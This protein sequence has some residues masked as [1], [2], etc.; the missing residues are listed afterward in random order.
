MTVPVWSFVDSAA[1]VP[2]V[3]V[4]PAL[5]VTQLQTVHLVVH[6]AIPAQHVSVS[7]PQVDNFPDDTTGAA[8]GTDAVYDFT[9]ARA[10]TFIYQAGG[11]VDGAR[12]AAMGLIGALVVVPENG[13]G[14]AYGSAGSAF[15]DQGVI[16]I[17][18]VDPG[19]NNAPTTFDMRN[20]APHFRLYNGAA[21]PATTAIPVTAGG[22]TLLRLVNG[23]IIQ[24]AVGVQGAGVTVFAQSAHPLRIPYGV[25]AENIPAGD[26][27]DMLVK[28]PAAEGL[29]YAVYDP[30]MRLDNDGAASSTAAGNIVAFGGGLT[31]LQSSGTGTPTNTAPVVSA[32]TIT[33]TVMGTAPTPVTFN[34]TI[35]DDIAVTGAEYVIDD[36]SV[37]AGSG[38]AVVAS[39]SPSATLTG[40][41]VTIPASITTGTHQ[42]LVRGQDAS[43]W[44]AFQ[45]VSFKVDRTGPTVTGIT[46]AS[47]AVN[48]AA[49]LAFTGSATDVGGGSVTGVTWAVGAGTPAAAILNPVAGAPTVAFSGSVAAVDVAALTDGVH[50]ISAVGTDN[51]SNVG[52]AGPSGTPVG[53]AFTVDKTAPTTGPVAVTPSPNDGSQGVSY[54]PTSI[55]VRSPYADTGGTGVVSGE[56]FIGAAGSPGTGTLMTANSN[57][58]SLVGLIPLSQVTGLPNGDTA[59]SVRAKDKAGN[60]SSVVQGTLTINRSITVSGLSVTPSSTANSTTVAL[61]GTASTYA[62]QTIGGAEYY[63]DGPDPGVGLGTAMTV[64]PPGQSAPITATVP[65]GGLSVGTHTLFVRARNSSGAWGGAA[66]IPFTLTHL[67]G[68]SFATTLVP[69]W[70]SVSQSTSGTATI[71]GA[72]ALAVSIPVTVSAPTNSRAYVTTPAITPG[73]PG[74]HVAFTLDPNTFVTRGRWVTVFRG[75]GGNAERFRVEYSR[76]GTGGTPQVRLVVSTGNNG[77]SNV[78]A[79]GAVN[80]IA[81]SNTIGIDWSSATSGQNRPTTLSVNGVATTRNGL[82]TS[83]R[84][85]TSGQL[86]VSLN[87][88]SAPNNATGSYG[89]ILILD[90]FDSARYAF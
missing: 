73:A 37:A 5:V 67:F 27:L 74:Y 21:F 64:G 28:I 4:G 15:D 18:D 42:L 89:G 40:I 81:G 76:N 19:L 38:T 44:G 13:A 23:G 70:A 32:L 22:T 48:G 84:T 83:N 24:H 61:A 72:N 51:L 85:V 8:S 59:I 58:T 46:P 78:P 75:M 90:A 55:E 29:K 39:G 87:P 53:A 36:G 80:L 54:D 52:A 17:S 12:Q 1:A 33:P 41:P 82:N 79:T 45:S 88:G 11:T 71:N 34:A 69:P 31:F 16:V 56:F 10:G 7:M 9:A 43:G 77:T 35:T 57:T 49:P 86:G 26:T 6:N 50:Y 68:N 3:P 63:V 2:T 14:T 20:F 60:W 25:A 62:G 47:T 30:S 65:V 66:S